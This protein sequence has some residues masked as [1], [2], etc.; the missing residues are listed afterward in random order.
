MEFNPDKCEVLRISRKRK[1][2]NYPYKLHN[3]EL[4]SAKNLKYLGITIN[5]NL[6]WNDHINNVTAKAK[7]TLRFIKRNVKTEN[8][9][10]KELAYKTYVRPQVEYCSTIWHPWQHYLIHKIEM[11]QRQAARYIMNDYSYT[12]SVSDMLKT[13]NLPT[14]EQR[15]I[16][17]SLVMFYKIRSDLVQVDHHHLIRQET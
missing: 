2:T 11:V 1:P 5:Q 6:T 12:S 14:L 4:K 13:L 7:N 8:K 3:I 16:H 9:K 15:R 17:S 10:V